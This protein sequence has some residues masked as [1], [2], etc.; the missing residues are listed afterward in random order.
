MMKDI[1]L[2][3][4]AIKVLNSLKEKD[5]KRIVKALKE[6]KERYDK[7][8]SGLDIKKLRG[9]KGRDDF[10]RLRIGEHR[11]IFQVED[12]IIWVTDIFTRGKNYQGY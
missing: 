7:K 12:K 10:L 3:P 11:I 4:A 2:H 1:R 6:L 8:K 5:R 9:T